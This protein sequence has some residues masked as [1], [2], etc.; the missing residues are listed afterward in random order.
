MFMSNIQH[1]LQV[2]WSL[3]LDE[4][5]CSMRSVVFRMCH[6]PSQLKVAKTS[7][8]MQ[9]SLQALSPS[10]LFSSGSIESMAELCPA[11]VA[12]CFQASQN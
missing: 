7:S 12:L 4:K 1:D 9:I 2:A 10:S 5:H 8:V 3:E 6:S 11:T